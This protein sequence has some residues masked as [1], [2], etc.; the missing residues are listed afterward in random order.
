MTTHLPH[1]SRGRRALPTFAAR[2][3]L[4]GLPSRR[5]PA[6]SSAPSSL[7]CE[8]V[9]PDRYIVR[10]GTRTLGFIDVIGAVFVVLA[11]PRYSHAVEFAQTLVFED[12]LAALNGDGHSNMEAHDGS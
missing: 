10:R 6:P 12:A 8:Q 3:S 4:E 7:Q 1:T 9:G 2:E 11:G 5:P